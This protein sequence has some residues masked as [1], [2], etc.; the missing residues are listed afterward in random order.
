MKRLYFPLLIIVLALTACSRYEVERP[1]YY[2]PKV[3]FHTFE[4]PRWLLEMPEG[5]YSIGICYAE[6]PTSAHS[7][8]YGKDFAAIALSRNHSS[9]IVDKYSVMSLAAQT[10]DNYRA[11][12]FNLVVSQDL[13]YLRTAA[14]NLQ[15]IDSFNS[16]GYVIS[17]Y[18]FDQVD[19]NSMMTYIANPEGIPS[20][21]RN[22]GVSL[23]LGRIY[24]VGSSRQA[25][26]MDA[27]NAAHEMALRYVGQHLVRN[28]VD[29]MR[30]EDDLLQRSSA[31]ETVIQ[32][33]SLCFDK[34]SIRRVVIDGSPSFEVFIRIKERKVAQ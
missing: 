32:S 31:F 9:Y 1:T 23:D 7:Q 12:S 20:W 34:V 24:S 11:A 33:P 26:L 25:T 3:E 13:D 22:T 29:I 14:Q 30:T 19:L 15:M 17:F 2:E 18:S 10:D 4:M 8:D 16:N 28:V 5:E 21:A 27:F 6:P